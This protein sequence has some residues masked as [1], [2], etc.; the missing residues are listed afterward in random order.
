MNASGSI[1]DEDKMVGLKLS[2]VEGDEELDNQKQMTDRS[3]LDLNDDGLAI[4]D[5]FA[6]SGLV[7]PKQEQVMLLDNYM[8]GH[9]LQSADGTK[10]KPFVL[11]D[12]SKDALRVVDAGGPQAVAE[13]QEPAS[14]LTVIHEG[15]DEMQ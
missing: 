7:T 8:D 12:D 13:E 5:A 2:I 3:M 11:G 6:S 14:Q 10:T 1:A 4:P 15:S 9:N